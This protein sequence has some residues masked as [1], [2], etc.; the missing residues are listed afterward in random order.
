MSERKTITVNKEV[1]DQRID[2]FLAEQFSDFSRSY[3]QKLIDEGNILIN[4]EEVKKSYT[5]KLNDVVQLNIPEA[6]TI[7][8]KP[9]NIPLDIIYEDDDILVVNKQSDLVVHPAPGHP[10]GTLVNALLYHCDNLA[11]ISGVKRPG[12]VHRLDKDTTGALVAAKTD[13]AQ[14]SL[15]QQFKE[16]KTKKIYWAL[17]EGHVKHQKAKIDAAVGRD[18]KDR[19][20]MAVTSKNS[21]KAISKFEVI[22]YYDDYT[23]VEVELIT[24]RTHQIRVHFD[25][26][27]HP[28]VGDNLYGF[29][30]SNLDVDRQMLHAKELGFYHPRTEQWHEFKAELKADMEELLI[31]SD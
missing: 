4:E 23:L 9:Q 30:K 6:E 27:G 14:Q 24:G 25:Y 21:K 19:K 22:D 10:D 26:I 13:K 2:K 15:S 29:N 5:L 28:V 1:I 12:I 17:V 31:K 11:G 20:K 7:D 16:R 8:L 18:P 3:I